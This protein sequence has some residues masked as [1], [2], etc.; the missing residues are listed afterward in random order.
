MGLHPLPTGTRSA[1]RGGLGRASA[2]FHKVVPVCR[3]QLIRAFAC[4]RLGS[5][6]KLCQQPSGVHRAPPGQHHTV[7]DQQPPA[8]GHTAPPGRAAH[9]REVSIYPTSA[10][11][12]QQQWGGIGAS[13]DHRRVPT[14]PYPPHSP[15]PWGSKGLTLSSM[16]QNSS[17]PEGV[18]VLERSS[19]YKQEMRLF[20]NPWQLRLLLPSRSRCWGKDAPERGRSHISSHVPQQSQQELAGMPPAATRCLRHV[21]EPRCPHEPG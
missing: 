3:H 19:L 1:P 6:G 4:D 12:H 14:A 18:N 7:S 17:H 21:T 11:C 5:L 20:P 2:A 15:V 9:A 16:N 13:R 10:S 8:T